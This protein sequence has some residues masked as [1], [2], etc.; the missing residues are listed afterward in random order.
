MSEKDKITSCED[1]G[2][3]CDT[4]VTADGEMTSERVIPQTVSDSD[5]PKKKRRRVKPPKPPKKWGAGAYFALIPTVLC[6]IIITVSAVMNELSFYGMPVLNRNI[7]LIGTALVAVSALLTAFR[8]RIPKALGWIIWALIPAGTMMLTEWIYA[9]PFGR[10]DLDIFIANLVPYYIVAG[11]ILFITRNT[12][13][14]AVGA[15]VF[16]L[17]LAVANHYV[18]MFRG[19]VLFPWDLQSFGVAMTVADNY[20]YDFPVTMAFVIEC[21]VVI[22]QLAYFSRVKFFRSFKKMIISAVCA[23]I[24]IVIGVNCLSYAQTDEF[25]KE[26]GLYPY[27]FSPN[28]VYE[29]NGAMVS[30]AY[31]LRFMGVERPDGYSEDKVS[32]LISEYTDPGEQTASD[33]KHP[34]IIV[35]MNEAWS[36]VSVRA[37]FETDLEVFPVTSSLTENTVRGNMY[38]SVLGGNTANSEFEF[39]TSSTMAFLPPGSVAYQQFIKNETPS[40]VNSLE[41]QGY[42]SIGMH[43]FYAD[44]WDRSKVYPFLGF[45]QTCFL[46]DMPKDITK[47]RSYVS[48]SA[49]FKLI[50]DFYEKRDAEKP[51][52]LFGVTMQNHSGYDYTYRNFTEDVHIV[53]HESDQQLSQYL[54]LIRQTDLAFGELIDYFSHEDEPT[55][56]L[57][58]GDHQPGTF[59][60]DALYSYAGINSPATGADSNYAEYLVPFIMWANYDIEEKSDIV[61]SANYLSSLLC[62]TA[63]L[64]LTPYQKYLKS[65]QEDY[66]VVTANFY[67][68]SEGGYHG[69]N[70][71]TGIEAFNDYRILQYN[72]IIDRKNRVEEAFTL[73]EN[74]NAPSSKETTNEKENEDQMKEYKVSRFKTRDELLAH[75]DTV[76]AAEIDTYGWT[77][78]KEYK[79]TARLALAE[80]YGFVCRME[81]EESSPAAVCTEENGP[82]CLDSCMEFFVSFDGKSYLNLETNSIG[83]KCMGFGPERHNRIRVNTRIPGG[84]TAIPEVGDGKW[85]VTYELSFDEIALFYPGMSAE[86]FVPGYEFTGNFYKTGSADITG[87]EHYG[88]W[89]E[90]LTE[91]P[92]FHRPEFFGKLIME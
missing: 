40:L 46:E 41:A 58:F 31:S 1:T 74:I 56:I 63:G 75:I 70:E 90:C 29:Y 67:M 83:T 59:V 82:V 65:L 84:F 3:S 50:T 54:S 42:Q 20:K 17:V 45:D 36:D 8:P 30:L 22:W 2:G 6:L 76:P 86:T 72:H 15:S 25:E 62:D 28:A 89:S 66:P 71:M 4:F 44:G 37:P 21:F 12:F 48:D 52:F 92:D 11:I 47:L 68:D 43:P 9:S 57:M 23:A 73:S 13:I 16:P 34:N 69:V 85:S 51:F 14:S 39:L 19:T 5:K 80:D 49:M 27:L 18:K 78:G 35:I 60:T 55:V 38:M 7:M 87:S 77:N 91:N 61:T 10:L 26:L 32:E 24:C 81:C 79:A 88:M 33:S 64:G 53:G